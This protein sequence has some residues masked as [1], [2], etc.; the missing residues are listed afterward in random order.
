MDAEAAKEEALL[1]PLTVLPLFSGTRKDP[2]LRASITGLSTENLTP[3]HL[4]VGTMEGMASELFKMY[5]SYLAAGGKALPLYGSG[6][7]LRKN[8][9]LQKCFTRLFGVAPI[10]CTDPEEAA[11]GAALYAAQA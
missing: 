10:L 2:S 8:A 6:N 5:E 9:Y 1:D 11:K 4:I 3:R 7:G